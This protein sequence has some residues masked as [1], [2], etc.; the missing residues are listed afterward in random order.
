MPAHERSSSENR[1]GPSE[2]SCTSSAV[3]LA[4]MISA[5]AATAQDVASWTGFMV[6]IAI[7]IVVG[8]GPERGRRRVEL[9]DGEACDRSEAG[10]GLAGL[11]HA[12]VAGDRQEDEGILRPFVH[13]KARRLL[14]AALQCVLIA[15]G[16]RVRE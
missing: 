13:Q 6:R 11:R 16:G 1:R 3:H 5:Q 4:P 12:G 14:G 15:V 7:A 9:W 2:R 8:L 10:C